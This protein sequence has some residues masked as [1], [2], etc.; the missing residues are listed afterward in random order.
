MLTG[1]WLARGSILWLFWIDALT[2]AAF[3]LMVWFAVP[4]PHRQAVG[5]LPDGRFSTV[6]RDR[7]MVGFVLVTLAYGVVYL[8]SLIT[9]PLSMKHH[10][11]PPSAFGIVM[12]LNG[13][14]IIVLQPLLLSRLSRHEPN[15]MVALGI[16][17]AGAGFGLTALAAHTLGFALSVV[18]WSVGEVVFTCVSA[19]I[20]ADL[21]PAH[22]RGRYSG[23]YGFAWSLSNLIAPALGT[24][25][26]AF[27]PTTLWVSCAALCG[28]GAVG[29][30]LLAPAIRRRTAL[31]AAT[32]R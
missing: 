22:L 32:D 3:G 8:Q 5:H 26:Y 23:V 19:A 14:V 1:G 10:G 11:L 12:A 9:L 4:E 13:I 7:V 21:A 27:G 24:R 2:C 18:V 31:V 6:L 15:R 29:Q 20:A 16:A 17:L 30:L 25:L 28:L